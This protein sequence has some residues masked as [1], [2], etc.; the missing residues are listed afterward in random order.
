MTNIIV[1]ESLNEEITLQY[2]GNR[3]YVEDDE[4]QQKEPEINLS[5]ILIINHDNCFL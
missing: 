2:I 5:K 4:D 1:D 3:K